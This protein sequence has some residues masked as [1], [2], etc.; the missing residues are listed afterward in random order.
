MITKTISFTPKMELSIWNWSKMVQ[1]KPLPILRISRIY[2]PILMLTFYN[3]FWIS[4]T[5]FHFSSFYCCFRSTSSCLILYCFFL[6]SWWH[7]FLMMRS[8]S[9]S[10]NSFI[11]IIFSCQYFYHFFFDLM[12]QTTVS[13]FNGICKTYSIHLASTT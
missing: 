7:L 5:F 13:F 12:K 11:F 8:I 9:I 2:F 1:S 6:F 4:V 10:L 3:S